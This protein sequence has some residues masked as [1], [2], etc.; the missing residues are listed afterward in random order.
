MNLIS[1]KRGHTW[2]DDFALYIAQTKSFIE[3]SVDNLIEEQRFL[4]QY[5]SELHGPLLYPWGFPILLASVYKIFGF[6]ILAMKI[7]IFLFFIA[8]L[9]ILFFLFEGIL[10][11][12]LRLLIVTMFALNPVFFY[13][14]E[15]VLADV[16]FL[17][18]TLL[19]MWLIKLY[20]IEKRFFI[21]RYISF[22]ILGFVIFF[23]YFIKIQGIILFLI[24]FLCHVV[25]YR[26]L[27]NK[28]DILLKEKCFHLI[29]YVIIALCMS[30]KG[31]IF[32]ENFEY[33]FYVLLN[34]DIITTLKKNIVYY[35]ILPSEFFSSKAIFKFIYFFSMPFAFYG[36]IANIKKD[37]PF[38]MFMIFNALI[39]LVFPF[40]TQGI[41][42]ILFILPFYC[43]YFLKGFVEFNMLE[44]NRG[45]KKVCIGAMYFIMATLIFSFLLRDV[46]YIRK[47]YKEN[48]YT[49]EGPYSKN[50]TEMINF[51]IN[52]T[53][54]DD[55][56]VFFK[57]RALRLYTNRKTVVNYNIDDIVNHRFKYVVVYKNDMEHDYRIKF[58]YDIDKS[59]F[60]R[61]IF[62]NDEYLIYELI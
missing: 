54:P 13:F 5:S 15:N 12:R 10:N 18:F 24:L 41:R 28:R 53:K 32:Y 46:N 40:T 58:R 38:A 47:V 16:P 44:L 1:F 56:L 33:F 37:Y 6:N 14:K 3:N 19:G 49:H 43:Y 30:V 20:I 29:P 50:A 48:R 51:I 62:E 36:F 52:F 22:V 7:Y 34:Q 17:F 59:H 42:Y 8:S 4:E 45:Y 31:I 2:G 9:F 25:E 39:L 60:F 35:L 61:K 57:P 27:L 21:N 55:K 11:E 26:E 23:A